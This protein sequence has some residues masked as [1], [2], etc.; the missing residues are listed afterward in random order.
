MPLLLKQNK[1]SAEQTLAPE[2][3]C[4]SNHTSLA[5]SAHPSEARFYISGNSKG[6]F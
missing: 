3:G 5:R 6:I 4:F 1:E 2:R